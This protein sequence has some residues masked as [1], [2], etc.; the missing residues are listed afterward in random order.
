MSKLKMS[1]LTDFKKG[2][3]PEVTID[4]TE[5]FEICFKVLSFRTFFC[6][7]SYQDIS[8][9]K[10]SKFDI[11]KVL[12]NSQFHMTTNIQYSIFNV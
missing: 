10:A 2:E 6:E 12:K 1:N 5:I 9:W 7:E 8:S 4:M 11:T 3:R